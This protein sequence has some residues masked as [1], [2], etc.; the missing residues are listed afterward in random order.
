MA[1]PPDTIRSSCRAVNN[2][3]PERRGEMGRAQPKI[4]AGSIAVRMS[5]PALPAVAGPGGARKQ[6]PP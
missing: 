1:S 4:V 5:R 3:R 6:P 2:N